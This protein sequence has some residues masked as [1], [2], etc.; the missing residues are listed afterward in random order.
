MTEMIESHTG[1]IL[2]IRKQVREQVL[3]HSLLGIVD[4]EEEEWVVIKVL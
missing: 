4:L 3:S 1:K 2:V